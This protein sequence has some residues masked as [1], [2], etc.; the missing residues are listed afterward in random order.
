VQQIEYREVNPINCKVNKK[1]FVIYNVVNDQLSF[2]IDSAICWIEC[3]I[4]TNSV[5]TALDTSLENYVAFEGPRSLDETR[6]SI[7]VLLYLGY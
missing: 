3:H 4:T 6:G 2:I 1:S 5:S 7:S